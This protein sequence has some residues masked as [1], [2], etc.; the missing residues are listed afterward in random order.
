[1]VS[2]SDALPAVF[3]RYRGVV[4]ANGTARAE[5]RVPNLAALVGLR[6]YT[7]LVTLDA[8]A[9]HGI[10]TISDAKMFTVTQ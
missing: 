1:M 6:I 4:D 2:V 5:L 10:R 8:G 7:A 9:P 3:Y